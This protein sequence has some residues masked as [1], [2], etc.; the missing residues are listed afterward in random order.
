MKLLDLISG[1]ISKLIKWIFKAVPFLKPLMEGPS[2][3]VE[4]GLK[5][6]K[7]KRK[8]QKEIKN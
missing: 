4:M 5:I 2:K 8:T 1:W 7:K 3:L 6:W